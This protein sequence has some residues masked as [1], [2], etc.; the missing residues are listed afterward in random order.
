MSIDMTEIFIVEFFDWYS[1]GSILKTFFSL[2]AAKEFVE[3][4]AKLNKKDKW[5][6]YMPEDLSSFNFYDTVVEAYFSLQLSE[7]INIHRIE[8]E[9]T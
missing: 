8:I 4:G 1:G 9:T 7:G 2:N 5:K 6:R 3:N